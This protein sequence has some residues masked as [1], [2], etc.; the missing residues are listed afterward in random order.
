[1]PPEQA[2]ESIKLKEE[3]PLLP[4]TKKL[5]ED[6]NKPTGRRPKPADEMQKNIVYRNPEA[7][8][9]DEKDLK[10]TENEIIKSQGELPEEIKSPRDG[11][12]SEN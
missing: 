2:W 8:W 6:L 3:V 1:M 12:K 11:R 10:D 9:M 4:K 7:R 5:M